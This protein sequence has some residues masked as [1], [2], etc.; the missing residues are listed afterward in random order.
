MQTAVRRRPA[1][2]VRAPAGQRAMQRTSGG[3]SNLG[4]GRSTDLL[5]FVDV[6]HYSN[7][8]TDSFARPVP[9]FLSG[10]RRYAKTIVI[11][12]S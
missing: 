5:P 11:S 7:A 12:A 2:Q 3:A 10:A 4:V 6:Q 8:V 9:S 1:V